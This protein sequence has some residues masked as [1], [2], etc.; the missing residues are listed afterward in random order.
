MGKKSISTYLFV[1]E[2]GDIFRGQYEP[3][4]SRAPF[5]DAK[6]MN[7][8]PSLPDDLV[9]EL[10]TRL[11]GIV[12]SLLSTEHNTVYYSIYQKKTRDDTTNM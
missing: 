1:F 2:P 10:S 4:I 12:G 11:V 3:I 8:H 6:I 9:A 5:H 7:T